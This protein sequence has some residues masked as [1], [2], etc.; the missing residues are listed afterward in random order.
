MKQR[1]LNLM[2]EAISAVGNWTW[3]EI[4]NDSIQLEFDNVQLYS[5]KLNK[6]DNYSSILAIRFSDNVFFKLFYNEINGIECEKD[7]FNLRGDVSYKLKSENFKF[8]DFELFE[9]LKND[10]SFQRDLMGNSFKKIKNGEIDFLLCFTTEKIGVAT[11]GN[12]IQFFNEFNLLNEEE[13][14]KLSNK[15]WF[16]WLV[17]WKK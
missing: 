5:P 12:Q 1:T 14:K 10:Y 6:F 11:G 4:A 7:F 15:W 9:A 17:P 3:M 16:H 2:Q 13:I 8:Q